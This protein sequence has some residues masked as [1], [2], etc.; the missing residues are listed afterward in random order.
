MIL[1]M[2]MAG[3][4]LFGMPFGLMAPIMTL[5]LHII[6]HVV[7]GLIFDRLVTPEVTYA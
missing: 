2:A 6:Y 4:G 3:A 5:A 7:L 1:V